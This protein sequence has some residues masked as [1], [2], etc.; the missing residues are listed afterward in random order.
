MSQLQKAIHRG[1]REA[2]L[3]V[4]MEYNEGLF[5]VDLALFLP[6]GRP[7]GDKRKAWAPMLPACADKPCLIWPC[8]SAD[9]RASPVAGM[10]GAQR[11]PLETAR[12]CTEA[13]WVCAGGY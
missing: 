2:G 8:P 3:D 5:S 7:G 11:R 10:K 13:I 9:A 12:G 6:P 1:L 4:Q